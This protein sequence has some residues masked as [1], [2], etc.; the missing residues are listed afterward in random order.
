MRLLKK[1]RIFVA[2]LLPIVTGLLC[3]TPVSGQ[4]RRILP[5]AKG[6]EAATA[7]YFRIQELVIMVSIAHEFEK[8]FKFSKYIPQG[9]VVSVDE[10]DYLAR[11]F[12]YTYEDRFL[13][14][15]S[16]LKERLSGGHDVRLK[17]EGSR[18]EAYNKWSGKNLN[19]YERKDWKTIN[20]LVSDCNEWMEA[21]GRLECE[22]DGGIDY[23]MKPYT[24][25]LFNVAY[26]KYQSLKLGYENGNYQLAEDNRPGVV[27]NLDSLLSR[28]AIVRFV[29]YQLLFQTSSLMTEKDEAT[30]RKPEADRWGWELPGNKELLNY[31]Q[32]RRKQWKKSLADYHN[33]AVTLSETGPEF[34]NKKTNEKILFARDDDLIAEALGKLNYYNEKIDFTSHFMVENHP[35]FLLSILFLYDVNLQWDE[36]SGKYAIEPGHRDP[37]RFFE[38]ASK[39]TFVDDSSD[40]EYLKQHLAGKSDSCLE[41]FVVWPKPP[42]WHKIYGL[43]N[44]DAGLRIESTIDGGYIIL[45]ERGYQS[46]KSELLLLKTDSEGKKEWQRTFGRV[47][48]DEDRGESISKTADGGYIIVGS[49][50]SLEDD[51]DSDVWLIKIDPDGNMEWDR[52]FE[53]GQNESGEGVQQ[54]ADGGYIILGD[55]HFDIGSP[56]SALLLKTDAEGNKE[57]EKTFGEAR[58]HLIVGVQ[59]TADGGYILVGHRDAGKTGRDIALLKTDSHG[60]EQWHKTLGRD[61]RQLACSLDRAGDGGYIIAGVENYGNDDYEGGDILLI[62]TDAQG[63]EQWSKVLGGDPGIAHSVRQT[64][65]GGYIIAGEV[66]SRGE[67]YS[68]DSNENVLLIKTDS[69][70]NEQ[71]CQIFGSEE[72]EFG[73][74]VQETSDGGY[75]IVGK[76]GYVFPQHLLLIKT[77]PPK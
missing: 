49:T 29:C 39:F 54:T 45:G 77:F 30:G 64:A 74:D 9:G 6:E 8:K 61:G 47:G 20:A 27:L 32:G 60:N 18:Y 31:Y 35:M 71:W 13:K 23:G 58:I 5:E 68:D 67:C 21:K 70:G 16:K 25:F 2:I 73:Y 63:N 22:F 7:D 40:S 41:D 12:Y 4:V 51:F 19:I 3:Y 10:S 28:N 33:I 17:W 56:W 52:T 37:K 46:G 26:L 50:Y 14:P 55:M 44:N 59:Q 72:P 24:A 57:W 75:T 65:D 34:R 42:G 48:A 1:L 36:A 15:D 53:R 66:S 76:V 11:A 38:I 69:D 43:K 62:K